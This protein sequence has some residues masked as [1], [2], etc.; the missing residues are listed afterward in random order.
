M[1]SRLSCHA[2]VDQALDYMLK[3]RR[4]FVWILDG[5]IC[6]T[7]NVAECALRKAALGKLLAVLRDAIP[8]GPCR[9]ET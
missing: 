2:D 8:C 7:N 1:R 3:G 6:L 9:M 5:R 4:A